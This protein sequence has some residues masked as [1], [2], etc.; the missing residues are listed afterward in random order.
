VN[1]TDFIDKSTKNSDSTPAEFFSSSQ[2]LQPGVDPAE[3][4]DRSGDAVPRWGVL[5]VLSTMRQTTPALLTARSAMGA[6]LSHSRHDVG[7]DVLLALFLDDL[8]F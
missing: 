6:C 1:S 8:D 7:L 5:F 4:G 3:A 2:F